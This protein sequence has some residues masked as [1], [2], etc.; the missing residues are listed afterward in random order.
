MGSPSGTSTELVVPSLGRLGGTEL[1][2][3]S[4][5]TELGWGPVGTEPGVPLGGIKR[6]GGTARAAGPP[7]RCPRWR[8][9]LP[10]PRCC[11]QAP[12]SPGTGV[13]PHPSSWLLHFR[14]F[15]LG[16]IGE[17]GEG[18][19]LWIWGL[20]PPPGTCALSLQHWA[21][22]G[23]PMLLFSPSMGAGTNRW[24][25]LEP[26][27]RGC[28]GKGELGAPRRVSPRWPPA[29]RGRAQAR[30]G[31]RHPARCCESAEPA[32]GPVLPEPPASVGRLGPKPPRLPPLPA[33]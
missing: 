7:G 14:H 15:Q 31:Q 22:L 21:G 25:T 5:G 18:T 6:V 1:C 17:W 20:H 19:V 16:G 11:L 24:E 10:G 32:P 3:S 26:T 2:S 28:A 8:Q 13:R 12:P 29:A 30:P 9:P 27:T 23:A 4:G 33:R